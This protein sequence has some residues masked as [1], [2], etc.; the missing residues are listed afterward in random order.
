MPDS[1][2][3]SF[4]YGTPSRDWYIVKYDP[5]GLVLWG[6]SAETAVDNDQLKNVATDTSGNIYVSGNGIGDPY[7]IGGVTLHLDTIGYL[8]P[9]AKTETTDIIVAKFSPSGDV[10]WAK[11]FG[12]HRPDVANGCSKRIRTLICIRKF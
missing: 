6:K 3:T 12:G 9:V 4:V 2:N 11:S 10:I 8:V 5:D 7:I 1:T